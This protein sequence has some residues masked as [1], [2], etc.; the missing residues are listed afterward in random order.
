MLY[1]IINF[2]IFKSLRF[3]L[4]KGGWRNNKRFVKNRKII[5]LRKL[6]YD[7]QKNKFYSKNIN[8]YL[9][10]KKFL[11]HRLYFHQFFFQKLNYKKIFTI[12]IFK[13]YKKNNKIIYP[14]P[15]SWIKEIKSSLSPDVKIN[16]F[17]SNF[18]FLN[19][20]IFLIFTK[21]L[22]AIGIFLQVIYNKLFSNNLIINKNKK[23]AVIFNFPLKKTNLDDETS[24]FNI[25]SWIKDN[26]NIDDIIFIDQNIKKNRF[27]KKNILTKNV[28]NLFAKEI[29]LFQFTKQFI[30]ILFY[31]FTDLILLRYGSIIMLK[32]LTE[33][34]L[35]KNSDTSKYTFFFIWQGNIERPLWTYS[36]NNEPEILNLS[37]LSEIRHKKNNELCYDFDGWSLS[38]WNYFNV[39]TTVCKN[40]LLQRIKNKA[41]I[42]IVGPIFSHDKGYEIEL[43]KNVISVF[44]Y[45]THKWSINITTIQEYQLSDTLHLSKFYDGILETIKDKDIYLAVKRKKEFNK[46]I[47]KKYI[48]NLY[49]KLKK[50][51]KVIYVNPNISAYKLIENSK[52]SISLPFTSTS[53]AAKYLNKETIYFDPTYKINLNDPTSCG[54]K[55]INDI[56]KLNKWVSYQFK[57]T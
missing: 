51:K 57:T 9:W 39:W 29:N 41:K 33:D 17:L 5:K 22:E 14:L 49:E 44:A 7:I 40:Y 28:I 6:F 20:L 54:V 38:T 32:S 13:N 53:V 27:I 18:L 45:E 43:P 10:D 2:K 4:Y 16:T 15:N 52:C 48:K 56:D 36:L 26:K 31:A 8:N 34:L 55:I 21:I 30:G 42:D 11:D 35:I 47:E 12:L 1:K 19:Y 50:N 23:Y 24:K 37:A 3:K 46:D 25:N